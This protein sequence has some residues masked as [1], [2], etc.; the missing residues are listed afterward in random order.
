MSKNF[1]QIKIEM[2]EGNSGITPNASL[3]F[4]AKFF[5]QSGLS[6]SINVNIGARKSKGASDS[7]HI[8]AMV[9]SQICGGDA[10]EHQKYLL[11]RVGI[12]GIDVPSVSA[13]RSYMREFHNNEEDHKRGMGRNFIPEANAY[14]SGFEKIHAHVFETA[15]RLSPLKSVTL[16]QDATFIYTNRPE[17]CSNY[18]GQTSY[19][20]FNTYCP[21]YDVI[22][23]TRYSDG[24]VTPGFRQLEEFK[25]VLSLLPD[26]VKHVKLRSDSAGYQADLIKYCANSDNKRFGAIDFAISC[27]VGHEFKAS[28]SMVPDSEWRPLRRSKDDITRLEW[29]EVSYAPNSLSRSKDTPEIRF[30]AVREAFRQPR[31]VGSNTKD[32]PG[33]RKLDIQFTEDQI[34]ELESGYV[35]LKKLHLT[36]MSGRIYKLF[37][38]ASNIM[39]QPGDEI[40]LWHRERCGKS[41]Q[42]HDVLKNDFGGSHVPS[43]HFGIN[44]AWWNIAVLS[45]NVINV[46]KR[47]F[48]PSGYEACRMKKLRYV[49]FTLAGKLVTHARCKILKL[50][51][52]DAGAN[53]LMYAINK[54]DSVMPCVT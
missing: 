47:F 9:I 46:M 13:C 33:Q 26:G 20:A 6:E 15:Y 14:L 42:A 54:L 5:E 24:N 3:L 16:D 37:G 40:I 28:A 32:V 34:N 35:E 50:Y 49:F 53:L 22:L 45:M 39:D 36:L 48:L 4:T 11:P 38:I 30:Y 19:A 51:S 23:G 17:T 8:M 2:T 31:S 12:L 10:I 7:Q 25:R 18:K 21:E 52:W 27:D 29:A 43:Y 41:E 44:A 1:Q